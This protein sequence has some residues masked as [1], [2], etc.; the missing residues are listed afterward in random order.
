MERQ[1]RT[2]AAFT[3]RDSGAVTLK[4]L[5]AAAASYALLYGLQRRCPAS[6][7]Q[8]RGHHMSVNDRRSVARKHNQ[9][10]S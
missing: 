8:R 7:A 5:A 10:N 4:H 6:I 3:V 2:L 1:S 9:Y